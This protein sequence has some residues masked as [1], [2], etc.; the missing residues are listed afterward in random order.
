MSEYV[1]HI[2]VDICALPIHTVPNAVK[3]TERVVRASGSMQRRLAL[4]TFYT[5]H[6]YGQN[7]GALS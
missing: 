4:L 5:D 7:D 6:E 1:V 2:Y 3:T